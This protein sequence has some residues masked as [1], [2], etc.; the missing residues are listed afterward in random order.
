LEEHEA[1]CLRAG[2]EVQAALAEVGLDDVLSARAE[3]LQRTLDDIRAALAR[4]DAGSYGR[5]TGCGSAI[6]AA[7]LALRPYAA[8]CVPCA[9]GAPRS[10]R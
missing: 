8:R 10:G 7:R 5:C 3:S 6:P 1:E 9:G 2:A 4:L